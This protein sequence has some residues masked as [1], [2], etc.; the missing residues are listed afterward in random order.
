MSIHIHHIEE[1]ESELNSLRTSYLRAHGWKE[2]SSTPGCY[3]LWRRDFEDV[4]RE[5]HARWEEQNKARGVQPPVP[6]GL[7][8]ASTDLAVK[9]TAAELDTNPYGE[10]GDD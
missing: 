9:M 2:T 8:T 3:W 4:D 10:E 7:V 6:F 1:A 5:R